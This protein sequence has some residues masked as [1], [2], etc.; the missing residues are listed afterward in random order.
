MRRA[1]IAG[2]AELRKVVEK[3]H[4]KTSTVAKIV[5][6]LS[7][8]SEL[9]EELKHLLK[10]SGHEES[11]VLGQGAYEQAECGRGEHAMLK[12]AGRHRQFV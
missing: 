3:V 2:K 11:T 10:T 4:R 7:R 5:N 9:L 12:V 6:V 1:D 8:K